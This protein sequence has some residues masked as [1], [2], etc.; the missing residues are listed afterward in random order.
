MF[1]SHPYQILELDPTATSAQVLKAFTLAMQRKQY[2]PDVLV[3]A[4]KLLMN[5]DDRLI[6]DY[7]W[8]SWQQTTSTTSS[9][10]PLLLATL[11]TKIDELTSSIDKLAQTEQ[12]TPQLMDEE[13]GVADRLFIEIVKNFTSNTGEYVSD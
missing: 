5:P 7:L 9:S 11:T 4:R 10:N 1:D 6:I 8:G 2:P 13:I 3:K 12:L